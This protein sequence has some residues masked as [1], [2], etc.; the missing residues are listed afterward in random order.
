MKDR[1]F[2]ASLLI[3]GVGFTIIFCVVVVPPLLENP[4][5]IGAFA[6]GF[7][8]PYASGYATDVFFTWFVLIVWVVYESPKIKYGWVWLFVSIIPG[9]AVGLA[10]YLWM[11]H[12]QLSK[13]EKE[14]VSE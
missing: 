5:I 14:H 9:V 7:V 6:A 3:L 13:M 8:N 2:K 1:I 12:Q 4:D 11:R 10:G